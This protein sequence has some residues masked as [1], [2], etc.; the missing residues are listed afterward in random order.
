MRNLFTLIFLSFYCTA[1][2]QFNDTTHYYINY[3]ST[4]VINKTNDGNSYVLNNNLRFNVSKKNYSVNTTNSWIYG[5]Q[6]ST[7]T[8]NDFSSALD[9][10][11]FKTKNHLYYW[12]LATYDKSVSL[13]INN[14]LQ[15]G[16]GVGYN[17]VDRPKAIVILSDGF[18][19]EKADLFVSDEFGNDKYET[20]R[21]SLRLK[22]RFIIKE[23]LVIDGSD[24]YQP[25]LLSASDYVIKSTTNLSLKIKKWLS[26]TTSV[27]YNRLTRTHRETLLIN[28]GLTV[29]RYF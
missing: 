6:Q 21:N 8:N 16:V 29:E 7:I 28:Y 10:N 24:F 9:F 18:L 27:N 17:I 1:F 4:G 2:A 20:I 14:R 15:A 12:G 23:V 11:L 3:A 13:K 5:K 26:F 22:F 19:Y 25:S